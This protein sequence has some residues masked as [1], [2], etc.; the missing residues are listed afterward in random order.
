V[1]NESSTQGGVFKYKVKNLGMFHECVQKFL[2]KIWTKNGV[3]LG[4]KPYVGVEVGDKT[5]QLHLSSLPNL[6]NNLK[7]LDSRNRS[8]LIHLKGEVG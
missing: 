1:M 3:G 7:N 2:C 4:M 5:L 8:L 6:K